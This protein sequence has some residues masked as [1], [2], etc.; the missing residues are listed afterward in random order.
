MPI[1]PTLIEV[2]AFARGESR[3]TMKVS[4]RLR[5]QAAADD[6]QHPRPRIGGCLPKSFE[7]GYT[8]RFQNCL[9]ASSSARTSASSI[10]SSIESARPAS[11]ACLNRSSPS[12][13][14]SA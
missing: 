10:A 4:N 11:H 2:P 7:T 3:F 12:C 5:Y 1:L 9:V 13:S 14:R 8:N 6:G